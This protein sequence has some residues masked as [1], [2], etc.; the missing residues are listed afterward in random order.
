MKLKNMK[1][2]LLSVLLEFFSSSSNALDLSDGWVDEKQLEFLVSKAIEQQLVMT[3]LN[4]RFAH[5]NDPGRDDVRFKPFFEP[6]QEP[7][8]WGWT[9]DANAPNRA[10]EEQAL[11]AGF[12]VFAEDYF[13][14]TGVT[15]VRCK[16]WHR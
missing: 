15:W 7:I 8:P 4:C 11:K 10:T 13:E 5:D 3:K 6:A 2:I 9:F 1:L 12:K 14:I 16:I